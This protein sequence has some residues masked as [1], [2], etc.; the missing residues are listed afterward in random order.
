MAQVSPDPM[1]DYYERLKYPGRPAVFGPPPLQFAAGFGTEV[2]SCER[3]SGEQLSAG[4]HPLPRS[5]EVIHQHG[6]SD[7]L[8]PGIQRRPRQGGA[9][10]KHGAA[11]RVEVVQPG[12]PTARHHDPAIADRLELGVH[13][14]RI[15]QEDIQRAREDF[16]HLAE[17][18]REILLVAVQPGA[19][20]AGR[21]RQP[22]VDRVIH[23]AVGF[24]INGDAVAGCGRLEAGDWRWAG[25]IIDLQ[26]SISCAREDERPIPIKVGA[27]LAGEVLDPRRSGVLDDVLDRQGRDC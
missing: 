3:I 10:E 27:D 5:K 8:P 1:Q 13:E 22:A 19:D 6:I 18:S 15:P 4:P 20:L 21:P 25:P 26:S 23:P 24:A 16:R 11:Q 2:G 12:V 9:S 14:Q 17:R 7:D